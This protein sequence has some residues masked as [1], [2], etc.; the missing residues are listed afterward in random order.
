[1]ASQTTPLDL[2]ALPTNVGNGLK[3]PAA[4]ASHIE[5]QVNR[6]HSLISGVH[7]AMLIAGGLVLI[8]AVAAAILLTRHRHKAAVPARG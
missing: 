6:A 3:Q 2:T 8:A 7:I 4:I 1:M 5:T